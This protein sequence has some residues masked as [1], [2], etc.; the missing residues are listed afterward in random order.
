MT[1]W[2]TSDQHFGHRNIIEYSGRPYADADTM[3][4]ALVANHNAL[5][6]PNDT[7]I[8]V[9]DFA[10]DE[11]LVKVFLSQ[12]NGTKYLIAGNHDTCHPANKRYR[13]RNLQRYAEYGF[14]GPPVLSMLLHDGESMGMGSVLITHMPIA[15][16]HGHVDRY[17]EHR[18]T[19]AASA[20]VRWV[21]HGHV[22]E[23]WKKRGSMVNVGVD[24]WNYRPVSLEQLAAY[25]LTAPE[26]EPA[27]QYR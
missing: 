20:A 24:A 5:V 12:L 11:R 4:A 21:L 6:K 25:L 8:M 23:A 19:D 2:L 10:L 9:G 7:V 15:G 14:G 17:V 18:P 16:D 1:T 27:P 13:E 3:N 26:N 22:H